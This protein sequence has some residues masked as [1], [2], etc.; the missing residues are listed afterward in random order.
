MR[1]VIVLRAILL[2]S[3]ALAI[4]NVHAQIDP[5]MR[6]IDDW[7]AAQTQAVNQSSMDTWSKREARQQIEARAN[8]LRAE[9]QQVLAN[10]A[11]Q[12]ELRE[13]EVRALEQIA[14]PPASGPYQMTCERSWINPRQMTCR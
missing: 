6:Q 13:R 10:E 4:G 3:A 2:V 14:N 5:V 7:A 8:Q 11:Y 9:R 1:T 12:R